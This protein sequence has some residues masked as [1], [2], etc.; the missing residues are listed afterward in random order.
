MKKSTLKSLAMAYLGFSVATF[1]NLGFD[2][3]RFYAIIIP[4]AILLALSEP[5]EK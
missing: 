2:N 1:G 5:D 4:V 3:W